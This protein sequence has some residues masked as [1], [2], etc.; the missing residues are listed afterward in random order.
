MVEQGLVKIGGK[1][2]EKFGVARKINKISPNICKCSQTCSQNIK[3]KFEIQKIYTQ[4]L[5]MLK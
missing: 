1:M 2:G 5:L 3:A 4:L